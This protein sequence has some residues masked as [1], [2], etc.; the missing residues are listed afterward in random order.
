VCTNGRHDQCCANLGRPVIRA[1][2][3]AGTPD[4]WESS[5]IGGDRFAANIV[6]LP[7][8]V[9]FGRVPPE[10]AA[11]LLAG[12]ASGLV[13]LDHYRGR[14]CYPPLVQAAE[15]Y[16]RAHHGERRLDAVVLAGV[17]RH[18]DDEATATFT[19]DGVAEGGVPVRVRRVRL[20]P[21]HLTCT[22][23]GTSQPWRYDLVGIGP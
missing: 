11:A 2:D 6:C 7:S 17:V 8:G 10:G 23:H 16:A 1:L 22:D 14:S 20:G 3:A 4:V 15:A 12:L 19:I 18:G 9:Y 21:Q 13:D 5:H